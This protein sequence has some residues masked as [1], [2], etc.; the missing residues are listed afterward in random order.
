MEAKVFG[1]EGLHAKGREESH[2]VPVLV[3]LEVDADLVHVDA[4][5]DDGVGGVADSPSDVEV[6]NED[7]TILAVD[8]LGVLL[9]E[10]G[11]VET[12]LLVSRAAANVVLLD[13]HK[14]LLR[15]SHELV[16]R[17]QAELLLGLV[18]GDLAGWLAHLCATSIH[19]Q[20]HA[21]IDGLDDV[22]LGEEGGVGL[23]DVLDGLIALLAVLAVEGVPHAVDEIV[24]ADGHG[25][26][27]VGVEVDGEAVHGDVLADHTWSRRVLAA[28]LGGSA[29]LV[30]REDVDLLE[31]NAKGEGVLLVGAR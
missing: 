7:V 28:L 25:E 23:V 29:V 30:H 18:R 27:L 2:E 13:L 20:V 17:V 19:E 9:V 3:L 15:V 26:L 12:Q 5:V 10:E 11:Q 16:H 1:L 22:L 8:V 31:E 14:D 6:L 4:D 21:E 24:G